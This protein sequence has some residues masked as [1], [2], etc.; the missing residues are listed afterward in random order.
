MNL[1]NNLIVIK[2]KIDNEKQP[3]YINI[4]TKNNGVNITYA[5]HVLQS[6][7]NEFGNINC[8]IPAFD[9]YFFAKSEEEGVLIGKALTKTFFSYWFSNQ[10]MEKFALEINRLGFTSKNHQTA[11]FQLVK[12]KKIKNSIRF[13]S[14]RENIPAGFE[15]ARKKIQTGELNA[16]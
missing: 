3:T 16:A 13:N 6:D 15:T 12:E 8:Y 7:K 11:M 2:V 4:T 14:I 5:Y 10:G 9:I 1:E